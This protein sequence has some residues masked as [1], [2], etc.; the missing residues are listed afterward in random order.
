MANER[1]PGGADLFGRLLGA[2][3]PSVDALERG[4]WRAVLLLLD[5]VTLAGRRDVV[6]LAAAVLRLAESM[7]LQAVNE[8]SQASAAILE[9]T[10]MLAER[11]HQVHPQV[12]HLSDRTARVARRER[13]ELEELCARFQELRPGQ[14]ELV[15]AAI[16]HL[17]WERFDPWTMVR[18]P[19]ERSLLGLDGLAFERFGSLNRAGLCDRATNLRLL[20]TG[21]TDPVSVRNWS[22]MGGER[23]VLESALRGL[24]AQDL[25]SPKLIGVPVRLGRVRAWDFARQWRVDIGQ[26]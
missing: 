20:A 11:S 21:R 3:A 1:D 18:H 25:H 19:S 24:A 8:V 16:E 12:F 15:A 26:R 17:T 10:S 2:L 13:I 14:S 7:R 9:A 4:D 23:G 6:N 5:A 22:R